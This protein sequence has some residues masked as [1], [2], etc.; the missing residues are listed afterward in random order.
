[1]RRR[2]TPPELLAGL[3]SSSVETIARRL[4]LMTTG[5]LSNAEYRKMHREKVIAAGQSWASLWKLPWTGMAAMLEPWHRASRRNAKRL[6]GRRR[7]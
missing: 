2:Q 7:R 5:R 4:A 3:A 6:R 1:M